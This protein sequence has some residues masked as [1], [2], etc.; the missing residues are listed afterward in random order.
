MNCQM[1]YFNYSDIYRY[2]KHSFVF[3]P[4]W[5]TDKAYYIAKEILTTELTYK[6]DLD[7]INIWFR[8]EVAQE[9]PNECN[10]LLSLIEPLAKAHTLLVHDLEHRLQSWEGRNDKN[11][12]NEN[13]QRV[14]DILLTH[15]HPLIPVS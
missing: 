13:S 14:G 7:V 12:K 5:T 8:V 3:Q 2:Q 15:L 10:L 9:K 6:K 11:G 1:F 4:R